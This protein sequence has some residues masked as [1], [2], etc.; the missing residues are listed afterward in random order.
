MKRWNLDY[1]PDTRDKCYDTSQLVQVLAPFKTE[2]ACFIKGDP[3][4]ASLYDKQQHTYYIGCTA[5][6]DIGHGFNQIQVPEKVCF[7]K[8]QVLA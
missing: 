8:K 6:G 4:S 3:G 2:Q 1:K 5:Q 7:L